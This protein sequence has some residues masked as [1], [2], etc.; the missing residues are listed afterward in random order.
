MEDVQVR[1][2]VDRAD[3]IDLT[4]RF[5][6]GVDAKNRELILSTLA[7]DVVMDL[8]G[9]VYEGFE[10][11]RKYFS[12][13]IGAR[14]VG[15]DTIEASTHLVGNVVPKIDGDVARA[16]EIAISHLAGLRDGEHVVFIRGIRYID[17]FARVN[18]RWLIRYRNKQLEWMFERPPTMLVPTTAGTGGIVDRG[19]G[20]DRGDPAG[21]R[22]LA[23]V[24]EIEDVLAEMALANDRYD[25]EGMMDCLTDDVRLRFTDTVTG[26]LVVLPGKPAVRDVYRDL[27]LAKTLPLDEVHVATHF[28][29]NIE[30]EVDGDTAH[31]ATAA[32]AYVI[33]PRGDGTVVLIRGIAYDDSFRREP[34]GWRISQRTH[35]LEWMFEA[36]PT[37]VMPDRL[38]EHAPPFLID[39]PRSA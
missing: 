21:A 4:Y 1:R 6:H 13:E 7:P 36:E 37:Y 28:L 16:D 3:I 17:E 24:A 27:R 30:V 14:S 22:R 29:T 25:L 32:T 31:T 10:T 39:V 20:D 34:Q 38:P 12:G 5:Q 23:D 18:G 15:L 9:D 11:A 26:E 8:D 2:L 35:S 33:G 19:A